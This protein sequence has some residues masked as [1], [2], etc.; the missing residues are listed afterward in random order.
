MK[1]LCLLLLVNV[2]FGAQ[3]TPERSNIQ[4]QF[5]FNY[6]TIND[7][8]SH[9]KV[10][11]ICQDNKGFMWFGTNEGL[12]KYD[13]KNITVY[14]HDPLD[15]TSIRENL[16]KNLLVDS[17]GDLWI[18][19]EGC[20]LNIYDQD[21]DAFIECKYNNGKN[22][23]N[24]S[25]ALLEDTNGFIWTCSTDTLFCLDSKTHQ[26]VNYWKYS[27]S[28]KNNRILCIYEDSK[29]N[30]WIGTRDDGLYLFNRK[31]QQ[32]LR[33]RNNPQNSKSISGNSINT[34]YEDRSGNLWIGTDNS[35]LN[36]YDYNDSTFTHLTIDKD[37]ERSS[38]I[39]AIIEDKS[40]NLWFGT[41][42]GLYLK[43]KASNVFYRYAHIDH[44]FSILSNNSIYDIYID[45]NDVMWLGTYAGGVNKID[46]K[47]KGFVHYPAQKN[48]VY[49]LNNQIIFSFAEDQMGNLWIG[50]ENGGVNY[51]NRITSKFY[52]YQHNPNDN[53]TI[54]SNNVKA[55]VIDSPGNL[56]IGTYQG[57][58]NR[59]N[60]K[61]STFTHYM[62]NPQDQNSLIDNNI[63]ALLLDSNNDL[64]IGTSKGLD[65]FQINQNRFIH[66]NSSKDVKYKHLDDV[67]VI[68]KDSQSNL[69]LGTFRNGL[70]KLDKEHN[71]SHFHDD[72]FT[73]S[74]LTIYEDTMGNLWF[75]GDNGLYY[76]EMQNKNIINHRGANGILLHTV[77]GILED[78]KGNLWLSTSS[79]GLIKF[80][81]A[82]RNPDKPIFR[83]Y[84]LHDGIQSKQFNY[85]AYYKSKTGELIFGG[86]N[87][88][89]SFYPEEIEDNPYKPQI[90]ITNFKIFNEPVP[91]GEKFGERVILKNSITQSDELTLSYKDNV[92]TFEFAA[93]HYANPEKNQYAYILE[94]F[95]K[96]W[97][98]IGTGCTATYTNIDPGE[99][100]FRVK[101]SNNDGLWNEEGTHIKVIITPPFWVTLWFRLLVLL[102]IT[103]SVYL[104]Y[105][106]R[107]ASIRRRNQELE[108]K[109]MERTQALNKKTNALQIAKKETD[110][111]L[112][113]VNE[114]LFLLNRKYVLGSQYALILERIFER[115]K[116]GHMNF[117]DLLKDGV[118]KKNLSTL[119]R[120]LTLMFREDIDEHMLDELNP[121]NQLEMQFDGRKRSKYLTIKFNRIR[122]I[123]GKIV[124]LMATVRDITEQVLLEQKLAESEKRTNRKMDWMLSILHV[125]PEML[126]EFIDNV[127]R[128]LDYIEG[129]L[130]LEH[131]KNNY[132][133][134]LEKIY[135]SMHLIKGNASLLALKFFADQAH[136]LEDS[137]SDLQ[138]KPGHITA[139]DM[140]P[141]K[142]KLN[143]MRES[144][145]DVHGL[146]DRISQI[147]TQMRPK[148]SYERKLLIQSFENLT[149]KMSS[150]T[151]KNIRL[152]SNKFKIS[153]IPYKSQLLV[154]EILIQFI[155]NSIAHGIELPE[156][157][158]RVNKPRQ[159]VIEIATFRN[160]GSYAVQVRDD[161]RG[162]QVE[163]LRKRAKELGQWPEKEIN[164]WTEEQV[165]DTIFLPGITTSDDVDEIAGRGVGMDLVKDKINLHKGD[166]RIDFEKDKFCQFTVTLPLKN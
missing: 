47:Q 70:F 125:E 8:L 54:S 83:K 33:Y 148:R 56:W 19:L 127:Q 59:F 68:Y 95:E 162:I 77:Y 92:F 85:N 25:V 24:Y 145:M 55:I 63:Y 151:G 134:R 53:K 126:K 103:G 118:E 152:K 39:R 98:Y 132:H 143:D 141:L 26:I 40:G 105:R 66:F 9:N 74:I 88:F 123:K 124:E 120:Y 20:G 155:R 165:V 109:V 82:I 48:N 10:N 2:A 139:S 108:K 32:F 113:N 50:T 149:K 121:G 135:R 104:L 94:G 158:K 161:G 163:K 136:Q 129:I 14:K 138:K 75:G 60:V 101:A 51:F 27:K 42:S 111:I 122:G 41:R 72:L 52:Y 96:K 102:I 45:T 28:P 69:W 3:I 6:L 106:Q 97:N 80:F 157:R 142:E 131:G 34:I 112:F 89:N 87:G 18:G 84:D 130:D 15:S 90:A 76:V 93:F 31:T 23:F 64:W 117:F 57:G 38:R 154:K 144:I 12:N 46:L 140:E 13:G 147:H 7:G 5:R 35:G 160:N 58:L 116:L 115:K 62:H 4:A 166:I 146:L 1:K 11:A 21:K 67:R 100:I 156:E 107:T 159:A 150:E 114:G 22:S 36:L 137:I 79:S 61:T 65:L 110:N 17:H 49:Y 73:E 128:E 119:H 86:I 43:N 37:H 44:D 30:L 71:I 78:R 81:D 91:I 164:S 99:Y 16:V 29:M 153:D 133:N